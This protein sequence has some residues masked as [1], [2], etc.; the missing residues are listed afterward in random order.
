[1]FKIVVNYSSLISPVF[2]DG[3]PVQELILL[4]V[5]LVFIFIIQ[6]TSTFDKP[7]VYHW[8]FGYFGFF[9]SISWIK[10]TANEVVN[11]LS[12]FGLIFNLSEMILGMTILAWGNSLGG[13][14]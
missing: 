13:K 6:F 14:K 3:N 5:S 11:V 9:I 2:L 4:G 1:L 8:A 12:T 10:F 7:P